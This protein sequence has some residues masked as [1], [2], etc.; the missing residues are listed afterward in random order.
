MSEQPV[1]GEDIARVVATAQEWL[2]TQASHLAPIDEQG[3]TCVCP[4][5]RVVATVRDVD[6]EMAAT[7]L[8]A[9]LSSFTSTLASYTTPQTRPGPEEWA[10]NPEATPTTVVDDDGDV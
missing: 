1:S 8:S 10:S 6:P 3:Q 2:R 5:C 4:L 9:A 7:W